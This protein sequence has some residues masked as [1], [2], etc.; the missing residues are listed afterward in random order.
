MEHSAPH[1]TLTKSNAN[2]QTEMMSLPLRPL[3]LDSYK[4]ANH[5][6]SPDFKQTFEFTVP[7]KFDGSLGVTLDVDNWVYKPE[8]KPLR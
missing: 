3:I 6:M 2:G 7:L 8:D 1:F 4:A 5:D